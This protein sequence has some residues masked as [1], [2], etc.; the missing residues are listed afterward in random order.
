MYTR[1]PPDAIRDFQHYIQLTI[2]N[3]DNSEAVYVGLLTMLKVATH[4]NP[5]YLEE[6]RPLLVQEAKNDKNAFSALQRIA[7][8]PELARSPIA[9]LARDLLKLLPDRA[10]VASPIGHG[11]LYSTH[12][13]PCKLPA[14]SPS[15]KKAGL[16]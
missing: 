7:T 14:Y 1:T 13:H 2:D 8:D 5:K 9:S 3:P 16:K 15:Y 11:S 12:T 6:C 4:N 10:E